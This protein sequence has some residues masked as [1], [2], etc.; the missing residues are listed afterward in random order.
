MQT[1]QEAFI[2]FEKDSVRVPTAQND[3]AKEVEVRSAVETHLEE[4]FVR[5]FLAGSYARARSRPSG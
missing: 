3:R 4:L 2:E 5:A 1:V